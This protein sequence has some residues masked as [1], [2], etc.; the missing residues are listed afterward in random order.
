MPAGNAAELNQVLKRV[1]EKDIEKSFHCVFA[2]LCIVI[3]KEW[4]EKNI[5]QDEE[6]SGIVW[7][8]NNVNVTISFSFDFGVHGMGRGLEVE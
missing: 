3:G 6:K 5:E 2:M 1:E 8:E 7:R 4:N